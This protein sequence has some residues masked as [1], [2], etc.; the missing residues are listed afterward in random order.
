[1]TAL[2]EELDELELFIGGH[3]LTLLDHKSYNFNRLIDNFKQL[4]AVW[5]LRNDTFL[6][7][8]C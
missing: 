5:I 8:S 4:G 2:Q 3:F 7:F 1:M 6:T